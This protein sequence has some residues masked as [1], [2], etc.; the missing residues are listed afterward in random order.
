MSQ[1]ALTRVTATLADPLDS[2]VVAAWREQYAA[3][4]RAYLR[5][6]EALAKVPEGSASAGWA[7]MLLTLI[8]LRQNQV[9]LAVESHAVAAQTLSGGADPRALRMLAVVAA[10]LEMGLGNAAQ[11]VSQFD[12]LARA[13]S[14]AHAPA[15]QPMDLHLMQH[16]RALA[17][18]RLGQVDRVL[19]YHYENVALAE[20][21]TDP[22]PLAVT[23]LN[24]SSA[25]LSVDAWAE[26]HESAVSSYTISL[27]LNNPRLARRAEI[28]VALALRY[29]GRTSESLEVLEQLNKGSGTDP[30]SAFALAINSAEACAAMDNLPGAEAHLSAAR[31]EANRGQQPYELANC[32]W[33][34]G[35]IASKRGKPALAAHHLELAISRARGLQQ[36]HV[37]ILP[38]MMR[39]LAESYAA[40]GDHARAYDT[41]RVFFEVTDARTQYCVGV[42]MAGLRTQLRRE[43]GQRARAREEA[44]AARFASEQSALAEANQSLVD[45]LMQVETLAD[46][47]KEASERDALTGLYNR[48]YLDR[49]LAGLMG[50]Q[51]ISRSAALALI[52]ID[53][54]KSV[55]DS[56]GHGVGDEVLRVLSQLLQNQTRAEDV[57]A[58]FGG[59]EFCL[60]LMGASPAIAQ[61]KLEE[62]LAEFKQVHVAQAPGRNFSFSCGI[63]HLPGEGASPEAVLQLADSRLYRAKR[64]GRARIVAAD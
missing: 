56:F 46:T 52:D 13:N 40:M 11:A 36:M 33:V 57:A 27:T 16:G 64:E 32:D 60:V 41:F 31:T 1:S 37:G 25:L 7:A 59:E 3:P 23:L 4:D 44:L 14:E 62:I 58:R 35:V 55:N 17:H 8:H 28:N 45:R 20:Q 22:A 26:A 43:S 47:F 63:A 21:F 30:G 50:S 39:L 10:Y 51:R 38:R 19:H 9:E 12:A 34:A 61:I 48:R 2:E 53:H 49:V 15:W 54:F 6:T 29:L 5:V 24:L 18:A 42:R